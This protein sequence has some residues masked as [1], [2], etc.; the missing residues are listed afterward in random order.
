MRG[1]TI[2]RL[3]A[4]LGVACALGAV[5]T[6]VRSDSE[7][8]IDAEAACVINLSRFIEWP[9]S[10]FE[11]PR[12]PFVIGVIGKNPFGL[13][14]ARLAW[15]ASADGRAIE[16]REFRAGDDLRGCQILFIGWPSQRLVAQI[17]TSLEGSSVLTVSDADGFLNWGGMIEFSH[18][19]EQVRFAV[20]DTAVKHAGIKASANLLN[21]ASH[22]IE[23][24]G[25]ASH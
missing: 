23:S 9:S 13:D 7:Q 2:R 21:L 15:Q 8:P 1:A 11:N 16:V 3:F 12:A 24:A 17:L 10:A 19:G 25:V 18:Q 6:G 4:L 22:V 5:A 14:L 20:N